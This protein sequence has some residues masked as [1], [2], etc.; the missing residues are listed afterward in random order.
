MKLQAE[1]LPDVIAVKRTG[2]TPMKEGTAHRA[3]L[4]RAIK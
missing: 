1:A 3:G 2:S 4:A